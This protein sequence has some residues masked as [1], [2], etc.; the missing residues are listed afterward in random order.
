MT[1][2]K[3]DDDDEDQNK[4]ASEIE[5]SISLSNSEFQLP[6]ED[7]KRKFKLDSLVEM[8]LNKILNK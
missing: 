5:Q 1:T 4:P 8:K 3:I 7:L 6:T 2:K